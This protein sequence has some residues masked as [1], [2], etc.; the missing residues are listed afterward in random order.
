MVLNCRRPA[1]GDKSYHSLSA[2][3]GVSILV[4]SSIITMLIPHEVD[5]IVC[6]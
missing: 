1:L 5:I 2:H 4:I 3:L 6:I